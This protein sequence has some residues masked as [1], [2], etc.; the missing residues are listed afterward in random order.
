M[1][2]PLNNFESDTEVVW[3]PQ[4]GSQT[5]FMSCTFFEVLYEGTRGPGKTDALIMDFLQHVGQGFGPA[6]R[7]SVSRMSRSGSRLRAS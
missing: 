2:L 4:P 1:N 7:N 6:W 5:L 3:S